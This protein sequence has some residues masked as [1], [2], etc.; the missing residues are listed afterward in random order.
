MLQY[1]DE[2]NEFHIRSWSFRESKNVKLRFVSA[3]GKATFL[4]WYC[5][6]KGDKF[7]GNLEDRRARH[8]QIFLNFSKFWTSIAHLAPINL[9][10]HDEMQWFEYWILRSTLS[11]VLLH[12]VG[13]VA[14]LLQIACECGQQKI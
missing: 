2:Q 14:R 1:L 10:L 12:K 7:W 11:G 4:D 6:H 3:P 9:Y 8:G 13:Q 5:F